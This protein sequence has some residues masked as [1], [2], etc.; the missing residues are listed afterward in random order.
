M[1]GFVSIWIMSAT[2]LGMLFTAADNA[3]GA[4]TTFEPKEITVILKKAD[5]PFRIDTIL[6]DPDEFGNIRWIR[7]RRN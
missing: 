2:A 1:T 3:S 4:A 5:G 7:V 6:V